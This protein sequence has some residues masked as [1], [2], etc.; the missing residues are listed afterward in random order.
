MPLPNIKTF[1]CA[2]CKATGVRCLNPA[3]YGMPVCRYHG[4]K[5]PDSIR[6][7]V[8]HGR[9]TS[10]E[11]TKASKE[12]SRQASV[13]L[14]DLENMGFCLGLMTGERTRGRKPTTST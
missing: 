12:A 11:F 10:G 7:G 9:Y 1:C 3:A 2:K 6:R 14:M 8:E 5:E 4:A 13:R